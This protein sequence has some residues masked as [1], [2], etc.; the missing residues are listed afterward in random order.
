MVI[1]IAACAGFE[2]PDP[3]PDDFPIHGIDVSR[4]QGE[5]DWQEVRRSGVEF[6]WIKATEGGDYLDP[7]FHSYWEGARA[8]GIPR[9]AYHFWYFCRPVEE[10]IAWFIQNVPVDPGA[11]PP[12]L[13][14]EWNAHSKTCRKRPPR[15]EI[16][17]DMQ[18]FIQ[19]LTKHYGKAPVIYS[20]V[21]FHRDRLVNML[22]A[23]QF[24][25][26]SVASHPRHKY[27]NRDDWMFWQYTAEGRVPGI[28]GN[29]DRNVFYGSKSQWRLWLR[30][31]NVRPAGEQTAQNVLSFQ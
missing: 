11:L 20:S 8:A 28:K 22:P 31:R 16:I 24:W 19:A 23:H 27:E 12:V 21:D 30:E 4:Y 29:V 13:D 15:G 9:G 3:T 26:R 7:K 5:I 6:V 14:M 18:I 25:L 1:A 17:R 10:Q 2:F